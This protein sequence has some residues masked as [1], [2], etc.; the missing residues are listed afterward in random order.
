MGNIC[1]IFTL[2]WLP[3]F[4]NNEDLMQVLHI[5]T[6]L[7]VVYDGTEEIIQRDFEWI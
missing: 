1:E 7:P 2:V 5:R 3:H 6:D 4:L